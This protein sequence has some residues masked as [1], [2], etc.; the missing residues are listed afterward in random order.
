MDD[1]K[2]EILDVLQEKKTIQ[3]G[4]NISKEEGGWSFDNGTYLQFDEHITNSIPGY[5]NSH[6]IIVQ[7]A[8]HFVRKE[9][10]VYDL[11]CST[12]TLTRMLGLEYR[13]RNPK[14]I[15]IDTVSEMVEQCKTE[16]D[17]LIKAG[18]NLEYLKENII[19][20]DVEKADLITSVFTMQFIHL[21]D[22]KKVIKKIYDALY[23]GGAFIWL[24]KVR[25]PSPRLQ[26][27]INNAYMKFK[28]KSFKPDEVLA[29]TFS[30]SSVMDPL[31]SQENHDLLKSVGFE[32]TMV[33]FKSYC[34]EGILA[35]KK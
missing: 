28:L 3:V 19:N 7:L 21:S 12:G 34:F 4:S 23:P 35:T 2:K 11:G 30:L 31:T 22:R 13:N 29:K 26:D 18:I 20:F 14:I 25:A 33:I 32:E 16:A 1:E 24:E 27:I 9:A 17:T 6:E 5:K 15:G 10:V 8:D